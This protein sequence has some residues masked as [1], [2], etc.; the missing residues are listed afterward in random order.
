MDDQ[1]EDRMI[2]VPAYQQGV[3]AQYAV[4]DAWIPVIHIVRLRMKVY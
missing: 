3:D 2:I 1:Q 4:E